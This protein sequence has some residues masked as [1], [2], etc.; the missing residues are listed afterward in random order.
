MQLR[1][2]VSESQPLTSTGASICTHV[3]THVYTTHNK[4]NKNKILT[5][6]VF[7]ECIFLLPKAP[8]NSLG[9]PKANTFSEE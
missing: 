5:V 3:H 8:G 4:T 7:T 6:L 2:G 1:I 9:L